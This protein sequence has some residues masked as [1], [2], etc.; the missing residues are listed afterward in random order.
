M[1]DHF[2]KAINII[3][4]IAVLIML[5]LSSLYNYLLFHTIAEIFSICIAFTVFLISWSSIR[6][7][8]I[9]I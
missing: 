1:K 4:I 9:T 5:Y 3:F 2:L 7:I 8:K 6:Y